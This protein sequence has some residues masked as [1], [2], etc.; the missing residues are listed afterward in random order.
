MVIL[1][2][3]GQSGG[4]TT[5]YQTDE[6]RNEPRPLKCKKK[7]K[8]IVVSRHVGALWDIQFFILVHVL[9]L[10]TGDCCTDFSSVYLLLVPYYW[11]LIRLRV[12]G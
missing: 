11:L 6:P 3:I 2:I 1:I 9:V 5:A 7:K 10:V 12:L 8:C 4:V